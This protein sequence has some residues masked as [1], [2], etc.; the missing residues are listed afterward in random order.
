MFSFP[1]IRITISKDAPPTPRDRIVIRE[2]YGI[3]ASRANWRRLGYWSRIRFLKYCSLFI[4]F[5]HYDNLDSFILQGCNLILDTFPVSD[6]RIK[7]FCF[8]DLN[9]RVHTDL[10]I[11]N[12]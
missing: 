7:D 2:L 9:E 10:G 1:H 12:Q 6:D 4:G 5:V 3:S 11:W 8:A